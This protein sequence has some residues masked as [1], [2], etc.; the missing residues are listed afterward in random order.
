MESQFRKEQN[1]AEQETKDVSESHKIM[2]VKK[3]IYKTSRVIAF[4]HDYPCSISSPNVAIIQCI[5]LHINRYR[6][7]KPKVVSSKDSSTGKS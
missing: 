6:N 3:S 1:R 7:G 2:Q 4:S 5:F